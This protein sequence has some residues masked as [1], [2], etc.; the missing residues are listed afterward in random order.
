[1]VEVVRLPSG[2]EPKQLTVKVWMN[3]EGEYEVSTRL[4]EWLL[5]CNSRSFNGQDS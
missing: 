2:G 1:M 3:T 4:G 5:T